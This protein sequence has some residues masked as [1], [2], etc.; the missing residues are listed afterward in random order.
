MRSKL[1]GSICKLIFSKLKWVTKKVKVPSFK[2]IFFKKF[3]AI[4][5]LVKMRFFCFYYF[6]DLEAE[7]GLRFKIF[8]FNNCKNKH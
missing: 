7:L 1:A 2:L 4:Y 8:M 6:M 5:L 3:D